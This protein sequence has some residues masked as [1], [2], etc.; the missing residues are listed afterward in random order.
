MAIVH[1][2][3]S[4]SLILVSLALS[5]RLSEAVVQNEH[6]ADLEAL[7]TRRDTSAVHSA[8]Y[9]VHGEKGESAYLEQRIE[10]LVRGRRKGAVAIHKLHD[11][12]VQK[13]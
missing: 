11:V 9:L 13:Q 8:A 1:P 4:R 5:P 6:L 10:F 3:P 2:T 7:C 12:N